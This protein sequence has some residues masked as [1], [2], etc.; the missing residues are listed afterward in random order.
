MEKKTL[1]ER[2]K[3]EQNNTS[4]GKKNNGIK[5]QRDKNILI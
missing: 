1:F 3:I 4:H 5:K 2:K